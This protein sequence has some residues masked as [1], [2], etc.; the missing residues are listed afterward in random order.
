MI[1][2]IGAISTNYI[3]ALETDSH[4]QINKYIAKSNLNGFSL[5]DYLK[6]NLSLSEGIEE[7]FV[8]QKA[9]VWL[10]LGGEYEDKPPDNLIPY[11]RSRNHFHNPLLPWD[12]AGYT[13]TLSFCDV[14]HCP[15]SAIMWAW[16]P[17]NPDS[18]LGVNLNPGGDWSLPKLREY[19]FN[20]L[21]SIEKAPRDTNFANTFRGLGQLMH[22]LEDM[23]VPEHARNSFHPSGGYEK[24]VLDNVM[25]GK[26]PIQGYTPMFS[27]FFTGT[28]L[29]FASFF[30]T[31]QYNGDN[32]A[33]T[34]S[35]TAGLSEFSNANFLTSNTIFSPDFPHPK[36]ENTNAAK[37]EVIAEDGEKDWT[38]YVYPN[39]QNYKLAAY[40]YFTNN[41]LLFFLSDTWKYH[42]DDNVYEDYANELLPR[43]IG[44]TSGL[45]KNFFRGN[46]DLQPV[47]N[48]VTF[49]T[50]TVT[51]RNT[52]TGG[53]DMPTGEIS[54]VIRYKELQESGTGP[55][56]TLDF[57]PDEYKYRV[58][59]LPTQIAIPKDNAVQLTFDLSADPLPL[60]IA[61]V[62]LQLVYNGRLGNEDGAV[63]VGSK[64]LESIG[65]DIAIS[66]PA[67][68]VYA[69]STGS[70]FDSID[71]TAVTNIPGGLSLADGVIEL[72][73]EYQVAT[74][75]PFESLPVDVEPQSAESFI[76]RIAEKNG[77]MTLPYGVPVE[78]KF[79]LAAAPLPLWATD[80]YANV[81]YRRSGDPEAKSIAVGYHDISEPT[82]V[83][84]F[85]NADKICINSSWYNAGSPE[86][87]ALSAPDL[88]DP[89]AHNIDNIFTK[90]SST[91]SLASSSN[92]TFPSPSVLAGGNFR[93]L[94]YIL[95]DYSFKYSFLEGWMNTDQN[96]PWTITDGAD[97]HT[98]TA[99]KNQTDAD[100]NY[101]WPGMYTMRGNKMWWGA[102]VIW[103]NDDYQSFPTCDW[104]AL[105]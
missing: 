61:D 95:T 21:T 11:R 71:L 1:L 13:S 94:G 56:R 102:S 19:Y 20:A 27:Q 73:L 51:A 74:T 96:D 7:S 52:T 86:A 78:L 97:Q 15:V 50:I 91:S 34:L 31:N 101:I 28:T 104:N 49:R 10:E 17:Q 64:A 18:F 40:S 45:L 48:G 69:K 36:K 100:G 9:K 12:Q 29:S 23:S 85:N 105:P 59:K 65:T 54:L 33:I 66:V 80:V 35:Y 43:A 76:I 84:V 70:N 68:G 88:F 3:Y 72:V 83:D 41:P 67:S 26:R 38:Y 87:I 79:D 42:L 6:N 22:L 92:Y 55:N 4:R 8:G 58:V 25:D 90:D 103:D 60:H 32:P 62:T 93:R 30:D 44:Y 47:A 82:P 14:G 57:P 99:V 16:G 63:A 5:D 24:W 2:I 39:G 37:V 81:V 75:D 89:Y 46:I 77:V 98:G 53:D